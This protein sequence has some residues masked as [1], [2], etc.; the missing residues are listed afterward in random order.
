MVTSP[1][2]PSD[3]DHLR[4]SAV[5]TI[6]GRPRRDTTTSSDLSSENEIDSSLF[7]K[8]TVKGRVLGSDPTKS[9]PSRI[10]EDEREGEMDPDA[11]EDIAEEDMAE[12][13]DES[14]DSDLAS[15]FS[16]T[17]DST[18]ILG[19]VADDLTS[20]LDPPLRR[21][22]S[23]TP[24]DNSPKKPKQPPPV[25]QDLGPP[26]P[27]SI[28]Q[29]SSLLSMALKSKNKQPESPF[30]RFATLS[31]K[32]DP[33]PLY[34]KL[35]IPHSGAKMFE[36]LLRRTTDGDA[37]VTVAE[38]IGLALYRYGEENFD[39]PVD[40]MKMN[41]NW[42]NFRMVEDEEVEFDFPPIT[43]TKA[44]TDFTSNN[45]RPQRG[46]ARDKPWDEF[47]LVEATEKEFQ[48]NERLTPKYSA[49][50]KAVQAA[51]ESST[52]GPVRLQH[53]PPALPAPVPRN[54]IMGP[55]FTTAAR[56]DS[57]NLLDA[58]VGP[59]NHSVPRSGPSKAITVHFT[60][61]NFLTRTTTIEVTTDTY[62]AE[63]FD[64]VCKKLNV[65]KALYVL[66]VSGSSTVAPTDRTVEALGDRSDLD[67][68]RRRFA[69]ADGM[70]GLGLSGSAPGSGS[71]N[72]P[73]LV[74]TGGTPVKKSKKGQQVIYGPST[75]HP[76]TQRN[77]AFFTANYLS[78]R[79]V[80]VRK[81]PMSFSSSSN[82][83]LSLEAE[84]LHIMPSQ[85]GPGAGNNPAGKAAGGLLEAPG[86]TTTVHYSSISGCKV[87]RSHPKTFS[88]SVIK[89]KV[90]KKYDFDARS[91]QEAAEI[92]R[93]I[94]SGMERNPIF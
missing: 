33:S 11:D 78:K 28:I 74:S 45:N 32:G 9:L 81:Q 80:V 2:R 56:K 44:I 60:D 68:V 93:E 54:P 57:S 43:R 14:D 42:F 83:I 34:I 6:T 48:E 51:S 20:P 69:A 38:A 12:M 58:P 55:A 67:L 59:V 8:R 21:M 87:R 50:A 89:E 24:R 88:F 19:E 86:K 23:G 70:A 3:N 36:L 30:E 92:V 76:L 75:V 73:L 90:V 27:I 64:Q 31:G 72:A 29:P 62:I 65:D 1:S 35:Y 66:K 94:R 26:R 15:D 85:E 53:Q 4:K 77:D 79:Y 49:E 17:A 84:Y 37:T 16:P 22:A 71:P 25:L 7:R 52:S 82:R 39:P 91:A 61:D 47:A 63:V 46:R 41:V 18:S 40:P 5:E 10:Q 13:D